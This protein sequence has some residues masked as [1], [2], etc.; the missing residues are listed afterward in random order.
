MNFMALIWTILLVSGV[1][2]GIFLLGMAILTFPFLIFV[3][4]GLLLFLMIFS[5]FWIPYT[6][7]KWHLEDKE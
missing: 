7:I 5:I 4:F 6:F 2:T 3:L 1:G